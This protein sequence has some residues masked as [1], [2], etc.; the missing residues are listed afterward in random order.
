[1]KSELTKTDKKGRTGGCYASLRPVMN[2]DNLWVIGTRISSN[3]MTLQGC[4]QILLPYSHPG[5]KLLMRRAHMEATHKGRDSTLSR[6]RFQYW[7]PHGSKLA[8]QVKNQC[9]L[10]KL[11]DRILINQQMGPL[12]LLR[13][14]PAPAFCNTMVD[15]FGPFAIRGEVQKRTSGKGYGIIFTD[16]CSRAVHIEAAFGYDTQSFLLA[17]TRFISI[18]GYP[19]H[20]FSDPG[21]Q[22]VAPL[23]D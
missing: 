4:P 17:F 2:N 23:D 1:M 21:S 6:F 10:C 20:M 16:L 15:I 12:P 13:L 11:R 5:T 8:Q 14:K 7:T 18:R 9:P 19:S 3:P 22:L